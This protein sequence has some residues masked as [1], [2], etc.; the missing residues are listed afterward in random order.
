VSE[1]Q[2]EHHAAGS[3][4]LC[5]AH[6][7]LVY[8]GECPDCRASGAAK[9]RDACSAASRAIDAVA[10][11]SVPLDGFPLISDGTLGAKEREPYCE[12]GT[13]TCEV[14]VGSCGIEEHESGAASRSEKKPWPR[15]EK[16]W[17]TPEQ[18]RALVDEAFGPIKKVLRGR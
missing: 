16:P 2:T 3:P 13:A 17:L 10:Q 8:E 12:G 6:G 5:E 14:C 18:I 11:E 15:V 9:I 4:R 7:V 1:R